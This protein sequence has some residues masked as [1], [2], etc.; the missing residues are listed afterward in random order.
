MPV[1]RYW[2]PDEVREMLRI[3]HG[4]LCFL[5][6]EKVVLLRLRKGLEG[7]LEMPQEATP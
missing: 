2:T 4:R 5:D 6:E 1:S 3:A 7:W